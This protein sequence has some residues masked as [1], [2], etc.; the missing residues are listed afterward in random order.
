MCTGSPEQAVLA[1]PAEPAASVTSVADAHASDTIDT[2]TATT[3]TAI[4]NNVTPATASL[5][6]LWPGNGEEASTP[7][8]EPRVPTPP[9]G[10]EASLAEVPLLNEASQKHFI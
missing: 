6:D 3:A 8:A 7:Q 5:I 4:A 1:A 10:A 9:S 2:T